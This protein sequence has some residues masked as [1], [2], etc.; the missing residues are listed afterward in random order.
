MVFLAFPIRY[1]QDLDCSIVA[2][3]ESQFVRSEGACDRQSSG[4]RNVTFSRDDFRSFSREILRLQVRRGSATRRKSKSDLQSPG[5]QE[6]S[7]ITIAAQTPEKVADE[8]AINE[9][10]VS[11]VIVGST[12]EVTFFPRS[13]WKSPETAKPPSAELSDISESPAKAV[14][15]S[16][17][18]LG[19]FPKRLS[20]KQR[21]QL[22]KEMGRLGVESTA[23]AANSANS[24][25]KAPRTWAIDSGK[26]ELHK[27]EPSAGSAFGTTP[28]RSLSLREI[29]EQESKAQKSQ[30]LTPPRPKQSSLNWKHNGSPSPAKAIERAPQSPS[31]SQ[32][33][34][35]EVRA[36]QVHRH[37]L[38]KSLREIQIEEEFL[39]RLRRQ[40]ADGLSL[41]AGEY[42]T[43]E[44]HSRIPE[45]APSN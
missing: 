22:S 39:D 17:A 34:R 36:K 40:L 42:C 38:K 20:Q 10:Q 9:Q 1:W 23:D 18:P 13:A 19:K 4:N 28:P 41:A 21:L 24:T 7:P 15:A 33:Q 37:I 8:P 45:D 5:S 29:M 12:A 44:R 11:E 30:Q 25:P 16:P 2:L 27:N 43:I 14:V 35:E 26:E 31:L 6:A 32:I 3:I